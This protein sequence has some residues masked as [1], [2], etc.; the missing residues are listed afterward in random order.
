MSSEKGAHWIIIIRLR[1]KSKFE[2]RLLRDFDYIALLFER[3][4][5]PNQLHLKDLYMIFNN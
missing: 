5:I 3:T 2:K 4:I 1:E